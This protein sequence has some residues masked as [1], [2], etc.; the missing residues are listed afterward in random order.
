LAERLPRWAL[1][2]FVAA[3][4]FHNLAM[5]G[6]WDLGVRGAAL[7]AVSAW[8]EVL[9]A[10]GLGA[11]VWSRRG[12]PFKSTS[13]DWLALAY[14]AFVLVYAVVPQDWL[15]GDATSH[16]VLFG[17][18]HDL[19]PVAAYFLGRGI[20]LG[21]DDR[22][23]LGYAI[24]GAAAVVAAWGLV[25]IF[26]VS[27]QTWRDS[28]VPGWFREQLGLDYGRGLSGL[29]ENWLYNTGDERP[30]RRLVSTFLSPLASAYMLVAALL[31]AAT[32]RHSRRLTAVT[33]LLGIGLL[34]T[35]SRTSIA[36]LAVGLVAL[37]YALRSWWPVA[38]AA[39][40]LAA[41]F[42]FVRAYP[43]LAPEARYTSAE[44]QVQRAGGREEPTSG[45]PLDP[46]E[47]S[48][49]SHLDNLRSGLRTVAE[50]PQGYG[51]GN[52]GVTAKRTGA[53]IKA[54][55]STY[56]E[57]GVDAG[58]AGA[59]ALIAWLNA[60]HLAVARRSAWLAACVV[61]FAAIGL[62]TDVIGV[63]WLSVVVFALA[64]AAI[65][66]ARDEPPP[67]DVVL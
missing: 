20:T 14:T 39:V 9:L 31:L 49:D 13:T 56:T 50:H 43:D 32:W 2:A 23:R 15:G 29:P 33:A 65:G 25:D 52:A 1:F 19:T 60:T 45:G 47:A 58:L 37:G 57:I 61:A 3:L 59:L 28:G 36:A 21:H 38:A 18:R 12:I 46:G 35:Y 30:L 48:F 7:D 4:P 54:G 8:K 5:A 53:E 41:A 34:F 55:E 42:F 67:E 6:L 27:L 66:R 44:L 40:F 26:A 16:G 22:R 63:H 64:G 62:Q 17:V 51:V 10:L 24:L 11:I